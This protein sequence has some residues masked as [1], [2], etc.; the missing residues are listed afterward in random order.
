MTVLSC[1]ACHTPFAPGN[2]NLELGIASCLTCGSVREIGARRGALQRGG[3]SS[4]DATGLTVSDDAPS[5]MV[6]W[7]WRGWQVLFLLVWCVIWN[8]I[9]FQTVGTVVAEGAI[10]VLAFAS[11]HIAVGVGMTYFLVASMFN[12]TTVSVDAEEVSVRHGP[13]PWW[14]GRI[15]AR[16]QIRQFYVIEV[17]GSKGRRTYDVMTELDRGDRTKLVGGLTQGRA[18]FLEDWLERHTGI[19]DQPVDGEHPF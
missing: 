6:R 9:L 8:S 11:I 17:R 5:P 2:V 15:L 10:Q 19:A 16:A 7:S 18:R 1:P 4:A 13:L 3:R 12:S 14:G